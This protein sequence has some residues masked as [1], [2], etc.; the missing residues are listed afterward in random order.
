MIIGPIAILL[1]LISVLVLCG[2]LVVAAISVSMHFNLIKVNHYSA[3]SRRQI[4]W[5]VAFSPW[6]VGIVA[7]FIA[8]WSGSRFWPISESYSILHWHHP[9]EFLLYSWHGLSVALATACTGVIVFR[10][11]IRLLKNSNKLKTLLALAEIDGNGFYRL[12]TDAPAAF[13]A[14]YS[15]PKCYITNALRAQL[16]DE[17]YSIIKLH[18][19]EHARRHDPYKKWLFQLLTAFFPRRISQTLNQSMTTVMEQCA[20]EAVSSVIADKSLIAMTLVKVRRLTIDPL[21][22][23]F[24]NNLICHYGM[25]N[26]EPRIAYLLADNKGKE[27]PFL[28]AILMFTAMSILCAMSA[29][30]FHHTIEYTL[31]HS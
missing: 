18:E 20:D 24:T 16:S 26:I 12:D 7:G 14:G 11:L 31:S 17:E 29:D 23:K 13:T 3:T 10:K 27:F 4:L 15:R 9:Q 21:G 19:R 25:D 5:L 1:N 22:Q 8:L 2:I 30:V 28:I 6:L